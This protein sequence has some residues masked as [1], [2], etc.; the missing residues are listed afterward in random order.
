MKRIIGRLNPEDRN[1]TIWGAGFSGLILGH[2][3]KEQG[4][5]VTIYEKSNKVGGKIHTK[6]TPAGLLETGPNALYMNADSMDLLK[7]LKLEPLPA[8]K[9][10]RKLILSNGKP[11]KAFQL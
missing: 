4:Y 2:Y 1:V 9:K 5:K 11:R 3:L 8:T 10:L 7:E 6:K